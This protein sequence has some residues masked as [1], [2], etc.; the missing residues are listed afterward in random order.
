MFLKPTALFLFTLSALLA[1]VKSAPASH[2]FI[3]VRDQNLA[4]NSTNT[5]TTSTPPTNN[6]NAM[7]NGLAA[8]KLNAEFAAINV[9]DPCQGSCF[10]LLSFSLN[11]FY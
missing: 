4:I 9:T 10:F 11:L 7:Q 2:S 3:N 6:T 5:T 8:Q 1:L